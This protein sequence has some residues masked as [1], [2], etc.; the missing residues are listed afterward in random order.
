P[1]RPASG[2]ERAAA[3]WQAI[4]RAEELGCSRG[5]GKQV[6]RESTG[7]RSLAHVLVVHR[8][9]R[10]DQEC[11][12]SAVLDEILLE[13]FEPLRSDLLA[14]AYGQDSQPGLFLEMLQPGV[15]EIRA[16]GQLQLFQ[17]IERLFF[18]LGQSGVSDL[19][20]LKDDAA[21][22]AGVVDMLG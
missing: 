6:G 12:P 3:R 1:R 5:C 11:P 22:G 9:A 7:K 14:P 21:N 10:G 16:I 4:D 18:E 20:T 2:G 19:C 15:G 17:E 13:G 8:L